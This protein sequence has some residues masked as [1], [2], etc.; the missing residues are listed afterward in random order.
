MLSHLCLLLFGDHIHVECICRGKIRC[1]LYDTI[2]LSDME[3]KLWEALANIVGKG[4]NA[5]YQDFLFLPQSF[6]PYQR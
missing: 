5:G 2:K 6:L 1:D 4:E 3:G